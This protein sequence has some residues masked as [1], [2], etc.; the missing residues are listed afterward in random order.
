M[1]KRNA[2]EQSARKAVPALLCAAGLTA[3]KL[4]RS[5]LQYPDLTTAPVAGKWY[6]VTGRGMKN[7][8]GGRYHA[9]FKKGTENRVMLYFAGGGL[10]I[11]EETAR[12]GTYRATENSIDVL[13]NLT[14]NRGGLASQRKD[15]PFRT[16]S[17]I[18]FPYATG[19]FHTGTGQ[20]NY[21]AADG[22]EKILYHN[23][24][25]NYTQTMRRV[26]KLVG[27]DDPEAVVVTGYSAGGFA[28][29]LL[30]D[31]VF[32]HYFPHAASKTVLADSSLLLYEDWDGAARKIWKTPEEICNQIVGQD[33]TLDCFAA[34]RKKY[35]KGIHLLMDSSTRDGELSKIQNYFDH[36][37]LEANEHTGDRYQQ[38]LKQSVPKYLDQVGAGLFLWNGLPWY[39]D[40]RN[41]TMHTMIAMPACFSILKNQEISVAQWLM[42]AVEGDVKSYGLHLVDEKKE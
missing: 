23:G 24:Y 41:L 42:N 1:L 5:V 33:L 38:M 32:T 8:E 20:F 9:F 21:T 2:E 25:R 39:A 11:N 17:V 30:A 31:D 36:G 35:G 27:L 15:N 40:P 3:V 22:T 37:V 12:N 26:K 14:A 29:A 6:R 4:Y 28:A 34:L 19:D 10:S 18:L 7:S 13:A 16:W